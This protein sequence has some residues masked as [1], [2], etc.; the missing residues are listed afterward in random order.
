MIKVP[1]VYVVKLLFLILCSNEMRLLHLPIL[2]NQMLLSG[3]SQSQVVN[4]EISNIQAWQ[5]K[6]C[7]T[8]FHCKTY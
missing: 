2:N 1:N 5:D 7:L 8:F 3:N 6:D 4:I